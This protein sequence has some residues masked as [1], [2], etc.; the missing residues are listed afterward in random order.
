VKGP[1]PDRS[2]RSSSEPKEARTGQEKAAVQEKVPKRLTAPTACR[3]PRQE[4]TH[5]PSP[6]PPTRFQGP[7]GD[8]GTQSDHHPCG[9]GTTSEHPVPPQGGSRVKDTRKLPS[10]RLNPSC[11]GPAVCV[12][13][14]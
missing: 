9:N 13:P 12:K 5:S 10:E 7:S 3:G 1:R 11:S 8:P 6:A 2:N 4:R 14:G